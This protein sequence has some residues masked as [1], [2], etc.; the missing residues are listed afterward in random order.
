MLKKLAIA[1]FVAVQL[2]A[3]PAQWL[4]FAI[5]CLALCVATLIVP[6]GNFDVS[7]LSLYEWTG[8]HS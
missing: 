1:A 6:V 7:H 4:N 5:Y 2:C 3:V 8:R